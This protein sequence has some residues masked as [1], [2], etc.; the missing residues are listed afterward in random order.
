MGSL[1]AG[2]TCE[3]GL[4]AWPCARGHRGS[5]RCRAPGSLS[6]L[7]RDT[8]L[9]CRAAA[10]SAGVDVGVCVY[11]Q[12][13]LRSKDSV[14]LLGWGPTTQLLHLCSDDIDAGA[15]LGVVAAGALMCGVEVWWWWW[16]W[17]LDPVTIMDLANPSVLVFHKMC[18]LSNRQEA[19]HGNGGWEELKTLADSNFHCSGLLSSSKWWRSLPKPLQ[20]A[21][22]Q[23]V[24]M[25][26]GLQLY[27]AIFLCLC[28]PQNLH[29][30]T[31]AF[32]N[33]LQNAFQ[34]LVVVTAGMLLVQQTR[35]AAGRPAWGHAQATAARQRL[36]VVLGGRD[37]FSVDCAGGN[38][39]KRQ[40]RWVSAMYQEWQC[41]GVNEGG[42][43][44]TNCDVEVLM[45]GGGH[46]REQQCDGAGKGG[47]CLS[48]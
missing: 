14:E 19:L 26:A 29:F 5:H 38:H 8:G 10:L 28:A 25:R 41:D 47:V 20:I 27:P 2:L 17:W 11:V 40:S 45:R 44:S 24:V 34:Q 7:G 1:C 35:A 37:A 43:V 16:W 22:Q 9:G 4:L 23:L 30:T 42:S 6:R 31:P 33:T 13:G 48:A 21:F 3:T 39:V 36:M 15:T 18:P 32:A 12:F 46:V